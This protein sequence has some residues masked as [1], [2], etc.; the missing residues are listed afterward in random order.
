[1]GG[2]SVVMGAAKD[3]V[4]S[5]MQ[6]KGNATAQ[7]WAQL[8]HQVRKRGFMGFMLLCFMYRVMEKEMCLLRSECSALKLSE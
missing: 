8:A 7:A 2:S 6:E 1:M 3:L 5:S 4:A